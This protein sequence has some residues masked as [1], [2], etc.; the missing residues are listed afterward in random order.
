MFR[1]L[2]VSFLSFLVAGLSS[3]HFAL[4]RA[5]VLVPEKFGKKGKIRGVHNHAS[6]PHVIIFRTILA[7]PND[8]ATNYHLQY[9]QSGQNVGKRQID[10]NRGE[11]EIKIHAHVH[12]TIHDCKNNIQ[13]SLNKKIRKN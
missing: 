8:E 2:V 12:K 9:L 3:L 4:G 6:P 10:S 7:V 5:A 1:K 11:C 13:I